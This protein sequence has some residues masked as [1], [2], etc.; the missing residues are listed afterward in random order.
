MEMHGKHRVGEGLVYEK[1]SRTTNVPYIKLK[2]VLPSLEA[3]S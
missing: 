2:V 3:L 1:M